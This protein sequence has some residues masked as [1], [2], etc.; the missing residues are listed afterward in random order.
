V[1]LFIDTQNIYESVRRVTPI[2]TKH[3]LLVI[4]SHMHDGYRAILGV[5]W[6]LV[7]E[8]IASE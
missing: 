8:M 4:A 3:S 1:L 2:N 6:V 5:V 7:I